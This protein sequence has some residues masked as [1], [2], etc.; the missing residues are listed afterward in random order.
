MQVYAYTCIHKG[1]YIC[2][3]HIYR[4]RERRREGENVG[5]SFSNFQ[6]LPSFSPNLVFL[7]LHSLSLFLYVFL[8]LQR[9]M[10]I[11]Q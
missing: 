7:F 11:S 1:T 3:S 9:E 4:E 5:N 6:S 10:E 8:S 2:I